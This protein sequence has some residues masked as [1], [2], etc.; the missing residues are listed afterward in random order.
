MVVQVSKLKMK[1]HLHRLLNS[2][3]IGRIRSHLATELSKM[4]SPCECD[5][6]KQLSYRAEFCPA[7]GKHWPTTSDPSYTGPMQANRNACSPRRRPKSS[8]KTFFTMYI[9]QYSVPKASSKSSEG[10]R[11]QE[12][13]PKARMRG[14]GPC[15]SKLS[16][17]GMP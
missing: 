7:C 6:C 9:G 11:I 14:H 17:N 16:L 10:S 15:T 2:A 4:A 3:K 12:Q 13:R 5:P 8:R 1:T